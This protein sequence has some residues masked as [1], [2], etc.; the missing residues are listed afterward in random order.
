M[1]SQRLKRPDWLKINISDARSN[2]RTLLN[3]HNVHTICESGLCPNRAECYKRGTATFL[4]CGNVC[5][6]NCKF[7][8]VTTGRPEPLDVNEP[9]KIA[10]TIKKM[11]LRHSVITSVSRDD[12]AD[13]GCSHWIDTIK[14]IH[15]QCPGVTLECLI[16]DFSNNKQYLQAVVDAKPDIIAHNVE[17]TQRLTKIVRSKAAYERS[18]AVLSFL[19]SRVPLVKSGFMVGLGE[20]K[21]EVVQTMQELRNAGVNLLTIGQ[22]LQPTKHHLPVVRYVEPAEF[23]D[24]RK[25]AEDLGFKKVESAPLVRS[26]YHSELCL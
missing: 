26:S 4:I 24:Y 15:S 14:E 7:C 17:T 18:L 1:N 3:A 10:N 11:K 22:Y 12:L 19:A 2:V 8:N 6:R 21:Q 25:Y 5:T 9:H 23:D 20:D 16:P 13:Y